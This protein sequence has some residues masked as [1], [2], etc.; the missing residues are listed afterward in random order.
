M[1][2]H[3]VPNDQAEENHF[4][5]LGMSGSPLGCL[6]DGRTARARGG[7]TTRRRSARLVAFTGFTQH[8]GVRIGC[9]DRRG[10]WRHHG[11]DGRSAYRAG[12]GAAVGIANNRRDPRGLG[13]INHTLLTV[14][15]LRSAGVC[16]RGVVINRY[17]TDTPDTA[18]E[19]NPAAIQ[20]WGKTTV[21]CVVP[22]ERFTQPALPAGV[23]AAIN[24]VDWQQMVR[25]RSV[26]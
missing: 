11:A 16:V 5:A 17:P 13:T 8:D 23:V 18:T 3:H 2:N 4:L 7:G 25:V 21:L 20:K 22:D 24:G 1:V 15:A 10:R 14:N 19:T 12:C 26:K 6:V 9:H